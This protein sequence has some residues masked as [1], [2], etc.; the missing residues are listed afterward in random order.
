MQDEQLGELYDNPLERLQLLGSNDEAIAAFLDEIDVR[1]PRDRAVSSP[2]RRS[3]SAGS[4]PGSSGS[5]CRC[6]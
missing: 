5:C 3:S 4:D 6:W 2:S 1:G